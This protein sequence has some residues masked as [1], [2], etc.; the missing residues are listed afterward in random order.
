M[1]TSGIMGWTEKWAKICVLLFDFGP[2]SAFKRMQL[3]RDIG[4]CIGGPWS[5]QAIFSSRFASPSHFLIAL[6]VIL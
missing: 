3:Y 5:V 1:I 4:L 6:A 2:M